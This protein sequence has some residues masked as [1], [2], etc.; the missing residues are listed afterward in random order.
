M[1]SHITPN[2]SAL[3][4]AKAE[5]AMCFVLT[6]KPHPLWKKDK[7]DVYIFKNRV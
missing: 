7:V 3:G 6:T 1:P 2:E 5:G 4:W